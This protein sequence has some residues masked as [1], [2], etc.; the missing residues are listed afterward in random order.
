VG[1]HASTRSGERCKA[2]SLRPLIE[3]VGAAAFGITSSFIL[4]LGFSPHGEHPVRV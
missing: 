2:L 3:R 4:Q 1:A